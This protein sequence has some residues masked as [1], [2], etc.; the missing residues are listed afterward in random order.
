MRSPVGPSYP[1]I[2]GG[3]ALITFMVAFKETVQIVP[4]VLYYCKSILL[5]E[6][7]AGRQG[8]LEPYLFFP[9]AFIFGE[10][11]RGGPTLCGQLQ[12]GKKDRNYY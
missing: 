10:F 4:I 2:T 12:G 9:L 6:E 8:T 7:G 3:I 1:G 11:K 5:E